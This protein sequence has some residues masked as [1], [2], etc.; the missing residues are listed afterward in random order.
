MKT[1]PD[2]SVHCV[3]YPIEIG[4]WRTA[5][6]YNR[7]F[8]ERGMEPP[9]AGYEL[10]MACEATPPGEAP[11]YVAYI[12]DKADIYTV[13]HEAVHLAMNILGYVGVN[14][15][16]DNHEALAYLHEHIFREIREK[17]MTCKKKGKGRGK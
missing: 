9:A 8:E 15:D 4:V 3:I 11:Y 12:P 6:K 16:S 14:V 10:G 2:Y 7:W 5:D 17:Q 1:D 13:S